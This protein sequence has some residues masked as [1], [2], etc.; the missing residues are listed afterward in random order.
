[1]LLQ[2]RLLLVRSSLTGFTTL[3]PCSAI[4]LN[5]LLF[6]HD[7]FPFC[8]LISTAQAAA[9]QTYRPLLLGTNAVYLLLCLGNNWEA[10]M[11]LWGAI[12]VLLL[13][14]LQFYAYVGILD[15]AANS[16]GHADKNKAL[17]GGASLDLLG[18]TWVVQFGT[19]LWSSKF[20]WL[21]AILP[22]WAGYKLY[23]TFKSSPLGG[24]KN[25]ASAQVTQQDGGAGETDDKAEKRKKRAER[26]RQKW[27]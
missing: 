21:L 16:A 14:G 26:R 22:P 11:A 7:I 18:L 25:N 2:R 19:V 17:V 13:L 9:S 12:G 5:S 8:T 24:G 23:S 1:M 27:S 10:T 3:P 15:D 20:Y 4:K 6:H